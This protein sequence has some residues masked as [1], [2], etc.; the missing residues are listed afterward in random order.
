MSLALCIKSGYIGKINKQGNKIQL[1]VPPVVYG[2][3]KR[4]EKLFSTILTNKLYLQANKLDRYIEG[5]DYVLL[6]IRYFWTLTK[7]IEFKLNRVVC[8]Y[9]N[10]VQLI[11]PEIVD[12]FEITKNEKALDRKSVV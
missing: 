3:N 6:L 12:F 1:I 4:D 9:E 10:D 5:P 2:P 8:L 7:I 11:D